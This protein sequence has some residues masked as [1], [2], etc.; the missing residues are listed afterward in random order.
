LKR[1]WAQ[2]G[3][4]LTLADTIVAAVALEQECVMLTDNRKDFPMPELRPYPLSDG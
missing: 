1:E 3:K 2:R 4:A